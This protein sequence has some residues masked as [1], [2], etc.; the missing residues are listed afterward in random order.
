[1]SEKGRLARDVMFGLMKTCRKLGISFFAY[2][3]DRLGIN[4][5]AQPIPPLPDLVGAKPQ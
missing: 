1:M 4:G 3:G 5:T 2:L